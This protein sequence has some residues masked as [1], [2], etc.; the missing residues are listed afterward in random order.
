MLITLENLFSA[1]D[2]FQKGKQGKL[3]VMDFERRLEDHIFALYDDLVN[4]TYTHGP[5]HTFNVYDPKFRVI[6]KATVRDRV[7]HHLLFRYFEL[8]FQPR[9]IYQSYSCQKGKGVHLA[10]ESVS[11]ALRKASRNY[12]CTVWTLK[13]DIKKFFDSVD[14]EIL[15][16]LLHKRM[17]DT[18]VCW[19]LE[20]IVRG[21]SSP[22]GA[23][24][25]VPIGNLTSQI[26]ANIYLSELDYFVKFELQE[27]YYFR[28]AD[29][30]VVLHHDPAHLNDL[31]D[32]IK[33]F[34]AERLALSL[35]SQKIISRKFSQGI[36]FLG[37]VL[38]PHY[39][40]LR[41]TTKRRI[42]KKIDM[43]V[44]EYNTDLCDDL[45]L[46]QTMQSY[47][48]IL[49]HCEGYELGQRLLNEIWRNMIQV[50]D[51]YS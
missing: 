41:T 11:R 36:D 38:L 33:V 44:E 20:R 18:D 30:F 48:G 25:G 47:L 19:L 46:N 29:D 27:R 31:I 32:K 40:I 28:Y 35:H 8:L 1:W 45:S 50:I 43:R 16:G 5:Y 51:R 3:D 37:Y 4:K 13:L 49:T 9:F 26:F 24:K 34:L 2:Q 22:Q 17:T 14:H 15:L 42:F 21:Y 12:T 6:N 7:V 10:V 39:S 23:G